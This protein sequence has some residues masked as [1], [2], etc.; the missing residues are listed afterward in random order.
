M[1]Y[2]KASVDFTFYNDGTK[3][4]EFVYSTDGGT[5]WVDAGSMVGTANWW[6]YNTTTF[7]LA[8][9]NKEKVIVRLLP[10]NSCALRVYLNSFTVVA[11][12]ATTS[13]N[14]SAAKFATYYNSIPIELPANL[15][16]ATIDGETG[17]ALTLN[18]RYAEGDIIPGGT[19]VVLKATAAGD[20]TL[21]YAANNT[22]AAPSGN[23]LY[24]SDVATTTTGGG[25]GAKYY[26]LQYGT[27]SNAEKLG[28]YWVNADGAA[29]ESGAHKAWLALPAATPAHFFSL[30]DDVTAIESLTSARPQIEDAYFDLMGRKVAQPT[31]GLYIVNGKKIVVK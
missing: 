28:F 1:R 12:P 6:T 3:H 24:G 21:T 8:A 13:V 16:A 15:Q 26:A 11:S 17:N 25:D 14:I 9:D 20:Y 30:D 10:E 22:D 18:Y 29:F 27:G 23:L 19:P 5:T 7:S 31:K 4:L 2:V